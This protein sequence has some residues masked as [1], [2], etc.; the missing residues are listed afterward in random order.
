MDARHISFRSWNPPRQDRLPRLSEIDL[1]QA[2]DMGVA[3]EGSDK[4][5]PNTSETAR[6]PEFD[7]YQQQTYFIEV[8]NRGQESFEFQAKT[9]QAWLSVSPAQGQVDKQ[10]RL[11]VSVQWDQ[12]PTGS[13][14]ATITITGSEE[15]EVTVQTVIKYPTSPKRDLVN[16]FVE[17][18]GVV[19]IEAEHYSRAVDSD[20]VDW[21]CVPHLSR[22]L[23]GMM[24]IP[25]TAPS[26]QPQGNS[27]RLEYD[28]MLFSSGEIEVEAYFCPTQDYIGEHGIRYGISFDNENPQIVNINAMDIVPDWKYPPSWNNA[29]MESIKKT[30]SKHIIKEPGQHTLKFWRVDPGLVLQKI[31]IN[32][33]ELKPSYLGPPESF[34]RNAAVSSASGN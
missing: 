16:G 22:K 28:M 19:S 10:V 7:V 9:A 4:W 30:T 33:S 2:A 26:D 31:V 8:F 29:V 15:T 23:S 5:W 11:A 18:N 34:F 1:P 24:T 20:A 17:G 12:V 27:P 25:V 32:T 21:L 3:I 6:L 13:H 14:T